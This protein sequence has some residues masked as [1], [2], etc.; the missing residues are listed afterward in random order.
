MMIMMVVVEVYSRKT[1]VILGSE[2]LKMVEWSDERC[3][4]AP[5]G[6]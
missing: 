1:E 2:W 6:D 5:D 3:D 4:D